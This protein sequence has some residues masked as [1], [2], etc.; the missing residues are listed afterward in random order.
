MLQATS[1]EARKLEY[2]YLAES[3]IKKKIKRRTNKKP[4]V[5][6][7]LGIIFF[8]YGLLL[9][10]LCVRGALLNYAITDLQSE[11]NELNNNN[12][13]MQY[14][15]QEL[16]SLERIEMVAVQELNMTVADWEDTYTIAAAPVKVD[17]EDIVNASYKESLVQVGSNP[18]QG[19]Y[20][21][22]LYLAN[23]HK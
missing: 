19:I 21:T 23:K 22:F 17:N 16:T 9:V 5:L 20:N 15:I 2:D 14:R 12:L 1:S 6:I 8:V 4:S 11:I 13:R 10:Y 3:V 7:K 18:M